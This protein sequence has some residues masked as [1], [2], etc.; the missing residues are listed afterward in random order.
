M[1]LLIFAFVQA[2][3]DK[4][5]RQET[6]ARLERHLHG[7]SRNCALISHL[8]NN[9]EKLSPEEMD[10]Y[11]N[12]R[13]IYN[14]ESMFKDVYSITVS[15]YLQILRSK[16]DKGLTIEEMAD[17]STKTTRFSSFFDDGDACYKLARGMERH[18]QVLSG[19]KARGKGNTIIGS[20]PYELR[21]ELKG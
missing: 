4:E 13:M 2:K 7:A 20:L 3:S 1:G 12:F 11:N 5:L 21:K 6:V 8:E 14:E 9:R 16:N 19:F 15:E 18:E 10:A 17:N